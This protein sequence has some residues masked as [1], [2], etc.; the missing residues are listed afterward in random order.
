M[1]NSNP[2]TQ[3]KQQIKFLRGCIIYPDLKLSAGA[4]LKA[5]GERMCV[6]PVLSG[7]SRLSLSVVCGVT[8]LQ[9]G[10]IEVFA[11]YHRFIL[12]FLFLHI[13]HIVLHTL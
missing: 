11:F 10:R 9:P 12:K 8:D 13:T 6:I 7:E 5:G 1:I 4:K 2:E 3:N